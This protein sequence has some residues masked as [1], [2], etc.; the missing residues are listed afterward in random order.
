M[1]AAAILP[2]PKDRYLALREAG[3]LRPDAA[4]ATVIDRLQALHELLR[5]YAPKSPKVGLLSKLFGNPKGADSPRGL[6][7]HGDVGRGKSM[8]MD[9]FFDGAP[10]AAKRRVHFHAFMLE[11]HAEIHRWRGMNADEREAEGATPGED[12]PIPPLA[13]KIAAKAHLLCFDEFQVT[14]V[15]DAM[16]L[17]RLYES[18]LSLGT[19]IVSTSNR[20]PDDLY[21][22]G[23]NRD[24]FLPFI[25]MIK[26]RMDIVAL[27]G[28]TDFRMERLAGSPVYFTPVNQETS[29]TLSQLFFQM[30]DYDV[31]DRAH[32]PTGNLQVQGRDL[33]VPKSLKGV[34]VFSFKRLCANPLGAADYLA[35]AQAYHTVFVVA[36]PAMNAEKRNEAK[37]FVTLIDALYENNVKLICSAQAAPEDLYPSGDGS[38]EFHRTASRL[39]EMQSETYLCKGHGVV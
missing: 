31:A 7:I 25:E 21:K 3:E 39:A 33:F 36:I 30:T 5:G 27:D 35:I 8:V 23:L 13:R 11:V 19:V 38:F 37:R 9:L 4:Q 24:L 14:D 18:L 16:I 15:A 1:S 6:Y 29:D 26:D 17:G 22:G 10:I 32:V 20:I 28:P 12:D 2:G 34:A